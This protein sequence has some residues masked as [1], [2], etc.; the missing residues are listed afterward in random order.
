MENLKVTLCL[1]YHSTPEY[2]KKNWARFEKKK[3][4]FLLA[5]VSDGLELFKLQHTRWE[6]WCL[7]FKSSK[8]F[9]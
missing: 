6:V 7:W 1:G 9:Q 4:I 2:I 3:T 5:S 8:L